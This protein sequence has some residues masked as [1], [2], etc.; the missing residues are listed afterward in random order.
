[1]YTAREHAIIGRYAVW[2]DGLWRH[3]GYGRNHIAMKRTREGVEHE[4]LA[5]HGLR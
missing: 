1:M 5:R 3:A 4:I 2:A